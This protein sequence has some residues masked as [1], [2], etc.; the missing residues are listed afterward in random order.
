MTK[1]HRKHG[2]AHARADE[3]VTCNADWSFEHIATDEQRRG[4]YRDHVFR[5][6]VV[7][8]VVRLR[9]DKADIAQVKTKPI[10]SRT[11]YNIV[12]VAR[13]AVN[14]AGRVLELVMVAVPTRKER[15][16]RDGV[17]SVVYTIEH[18]GSDK[19]RREETK[20]LRRVH[21]LIS[22]DTPYTV[23]TEST[24]SAIKLPIWKPIAAN[25]PDKRCYPI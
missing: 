16:A 22:Y 13:P 17:R 3:N 4:E 2:H 21:R 12:H 25:G 6:D 8:Q 18:D 1:H 20:S 15:A 19:V 7:F 14:P 9:A 24:S 11:T 10:V 5:Y 23:H